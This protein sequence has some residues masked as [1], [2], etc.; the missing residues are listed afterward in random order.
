M[1]IAPNTNSFPFMWV[2]PPV[3]TYSRT[4]RYKSQSPRTL[5]QRQSSAVSGG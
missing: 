3:R 1:K 4:K 2:T 5:P